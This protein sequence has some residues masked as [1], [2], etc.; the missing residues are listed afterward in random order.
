MSLPEFTAE[1][2]LY[3]TNR[4][5]HTTLLRAGWSGS[6]VIAQGPADEQTSAI[7]SCGLAWLLCIWFEDPWWCKWYN[8]NPRCLCTPNCDDHCKPDPAVIDPATGYG[9][10]ECVDVHCM[11]YKVFC[12]L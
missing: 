8:T 11:P 12:K 5:Y 1:E 9:T 2:S 7:A 10:I 4:A 6:S 3:K